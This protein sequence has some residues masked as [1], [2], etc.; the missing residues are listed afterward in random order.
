MASTAVGT[1]STFGKASEGAAP[2]I[3]D[4]PVSS[5]NPTVLTV[6]DRATQLVIIPH[7]DMHF[8]WGESGVA[9]AAKTIID[10]DDSRGKLPSGMA[11]VIPV[12]GWSSF[13]YVRSTG[14]AVTDG[15]TYFWVE[16]D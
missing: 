3:V 16:E 10:T 4:L 9:A 12:S 13:F 2:K 14:A 7:A 6:P 1:R 8:S 15:I 5:G 11:M